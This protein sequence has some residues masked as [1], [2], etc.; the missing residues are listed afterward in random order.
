MKTAESE[1]IKRVFKTVPIPGAKNGKYAVLECGH[2]V[3]A[4]GDQKR[5]DC[6]QCRLIAEK[7]QR[8]H[9]RGG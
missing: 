8:S 5:F 7:A 4:I 1:H 3:I 6:L 2:H 9:L